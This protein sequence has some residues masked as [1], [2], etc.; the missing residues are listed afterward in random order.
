M[1]FSASNGAMID[2]Y[3][4][5]IAQM[6][7][8][9]ERRVSVGDLIVACDAVANTMGTY[10]AFS[11]NCKVTVDGAV[12]SVPK[13]SA[14][15]SLNVQPITVWSDTVLWRPVQ[16]LQGDALEAAR[17]APIDSVLYLDPPYVKRAYGPNYFV[18]NVIADVEQEPLLKGKTGIPSYEGEV[19][20]NRSNWNTLNG[21][22]ESLRAILAVTRAK[23]VVLSYSTDGLMPDK[24][25]LDL[26]QEQ[27]FKVDKHAFEHPRYNTG[28]SDAATLH[29]LLYCAEKK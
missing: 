27:G 19:S 21:S 22:V 24:T 11:K 13:K 4:A 2:G 26:F 17:I 14:Q 15:K 20:Y 16:V 28:Q 18:L 8:G 3:R 29:E 23:R 7:D 6:L 9:P 12:V 10:G 25:I 1:F 5:Q